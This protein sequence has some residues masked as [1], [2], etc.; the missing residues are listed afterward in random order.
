MWHK[1]KHSESGVA[2]QPLHTLAFWQWFL[3]TGSTPRR[4]YA[5]YTHTH[6]QMILMEVRDGVADGAATAAQTSAVCIIIFS[7]KTGGATFVYFIVAIWILFH[8]SSIFSPFVFIHLAGTGA[9]GFVVRT[10]KG[11]TLVQC[12]TRSFLLF[13]IHIVWNSWCEYVNHSE[14]V[15]RRFGAETNTHIRWLIHSR[16]LVPHTIISRLVSFAYAASFSCFCV[17]G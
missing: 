1:H 10:T 4:T 7:Y 3:G 11:K 14:S 5:V 15:S 2:A 8:F 9:V 6:T 13:T 17:A 16:S 12:S